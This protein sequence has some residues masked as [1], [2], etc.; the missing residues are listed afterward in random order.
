MLD[1][2]ILGLV[3]AWAIGG[4]FRGSVRQTFGTVGLAAGLWVVLEVSRWVGAQWA[5][6][7]PVVL[8]WS[9]RWVVAGLAGLAVSSLFHW[10]GVS[11]G[12]AVQAGPAGWLDRVL[13]VLLGALIG[14]VWVTAFVTIVLIAPRTLGMGRAVAHARTP[15]ALVA[16]GAWTCDAVEARVPAVHGVGRWLH[17][18]ERR[19][20]SHSRGS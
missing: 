20:R 5:G 17:E 19:A 15:K 10:W 1:W 16:A 14:M 4:A 2:V 13:G 9:L 12:R 6:A 11:L 18:A 8:F 3:A 7:R